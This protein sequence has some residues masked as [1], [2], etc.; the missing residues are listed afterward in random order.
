V[1]DDP[2]DAAASKGGFAPEGYENSLNT[3]HVFDRFSSR[4]SVEPSQCLRC[5]AASISTCMP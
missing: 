3:D 4:V 1:D 5:V 2:D